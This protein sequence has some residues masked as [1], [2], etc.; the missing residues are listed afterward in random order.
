[1]QEA[2]KAGAA[3]LRYSGRRNRVC[4]GGHCL[5]VFQ[6]RQASPAGAG[7]RTGKWILPCIL[8]LHLREPWSKSLKLGAILSPSVDAIDAKFSICNLQSISRG[9]RREF[10]RD[11]LRQVDQSAVWDWR[12]LGSVPE[13]RRQLAL[14]FALCWCAQAAPACGLPNSARTNSSAIP[15]AVGRRKRP[16]GTAGL[17]HQ[18][19]DWSLNPLW[20]AL[21]CWI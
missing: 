10:E 13:S 15:A 19:R 16:R 9:G 17:N 1:V 21:S 3:Y 6:P 4:G 8:L 5:H 14:T 18:F 2:L 11:R 12:Y 7:H 20:I